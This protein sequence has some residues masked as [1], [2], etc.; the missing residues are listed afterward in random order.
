MLGYEMVGLIDLFF[1]YVNILY[2]DQYSVRNRVPPALINY[3][4]KNMKIKSSVTGYW[5]TFFC[6]KANPINRD[7]SLWHILHIK[8]SPSCVAFPVKSKFVADSVLVIY[9]RW[10][11]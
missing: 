10:S 1:L 5:N 9:S 6:E 8:A 2:L 11:V 7:K 4:V 3:V